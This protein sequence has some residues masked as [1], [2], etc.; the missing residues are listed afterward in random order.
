MRVSEP[1]RRSSEDGTAA[2]EAVVTISVLLLLILG[3]VEFGQAFWTYNTMLLAVEEAGRYAMVHNQ[4]PPE[5]CAAQNQAPQ[6]PTLS[7]TALAN[8]S[9][10]LAQQFLFA[11]QA[12]NIGVSVTEDRTSSPAT[13]TICA[14]YSLD[15]IAPQLVPYGALTLARQ[16]TVPLI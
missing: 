5:V 6:C 8:C 7:N 4:G 2:V 16:V 15:F 12:P 3:I 9:A 13:I 1:S 10:A 14:S 11:Y